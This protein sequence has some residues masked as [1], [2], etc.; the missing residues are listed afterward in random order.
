MKRAWVPLFALLTGLAATVIATWLLANDFEI[1]A[2]AEFNDAAQAAADTID[3]RLEAYV[4]LLR[5]CSGLFAVQR[6]VTSGEFRAFVDR[7]QVAEEYPGVQGIGFAMRTPKAGKEALVARMR[8]QG[9]DGFA[10]WPEGERE[11]YFP[12]ILLEPA[13]HRN[14]AAIGYDTFSDPVRHTAMERARDAGTAVASGKVTLVQEIEGPAQAGF[15][16][17]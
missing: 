17:Y 11:E 3:E 5:G 13:D 6:E 16:I 15:L 12:I 8:S 14:R 2:R 7:L 9:N 10:I 1:K 4:A